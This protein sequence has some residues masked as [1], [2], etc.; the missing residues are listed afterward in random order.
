M[1]D[2]D[3]RNGGLAGHASLALIVALAGVASP[4][5]ARASAPVVRLDVPRQAVR[6]ALLDLAV[7]ARVSLGGDL[8]SCRG[9]TAGVSGVMTVDAAL[10]RLLAGSGCVH[11]IRAD[12]AVMI[13]RAPPP[14]ASTGAR[15]APPR[16][17]RPPSRPVAGPSSPIETTMVSD[18]IV[19]AQRQPQS[20]QETAAALTAVSG[21][22]IVAAGAADANDLSALVAGMTVT[23][24]G[25]GRNKILLRG[26]SDGAFTGLTQSTVG[27]YLNRVPLTY[28]A[29]DPDLKLVDIDRVEILRGPQGTLYGTGPIGGVLRIVP[30][31]PDPDDETL[32]L[33]GSISNTRSG[34]E[35]S[36]YGVIVNAPL[37]GERGAVR[38]VAYREAAD[39]YINDAN[40][41]LRRVNAGERR[42]QRLSALYRLS[43]EWTITA[44][45]VRQQI[46]T[47]DTHYIYRTSQGLTRANLVREP[48]AN[49]FAQTY[50]TLEGHGAWGRVEATLAKVSHDFSSRYDAS[51]A[52]RLFGSSGR[53]GA[54]D[55]GR[56]TD[57]WVG[58]VAFVSPR[59]QRFRWLA[60]GF[61]SD[62]RS[63]TDT[64]LQ[65]LWPQYG[66]VYSED[67]DD[68]RSEAAVFGEAAYDLTSRLSVI[69]GARYYRIDYEVDSL[70]EQGDAAR[71]F[72]GAGRTSGI[73]PKAVVDFT[74]NDRWSVYVLASQG[75]RVGGFNTGGP[76]GQS[77]SGAVGKPARRY[78]GDSLWN[79]ETG[80]KG[81]LFD[82]RLQARVALFH[83]EWDSLQSDQFLRSGLVYA[84][85]VGDGANTGLELE[86]NWRATAEL[87]MRANALF[88]DP[89]I[90][91]P[92]DAFNSRGDAGLPG[93]PAVSAN[94]NVAWR[95]GTPWGVDMVAEGRL[96]YV[97]PSRLTFDAARGYRMG[98][99]VT[100]RLSVGL[101]RSDWSASVF[102][103]NP[104]DTRANT[105]S[106]GDPFR[107][108]EALAT[109]PLRPRTVGLS[110]RWTPL[111]G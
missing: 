79:F 70:V 107:L 22:Q 44:G 71:E 13:R 105:F 110:L 62:S 68:R 55:E 111:G 80:A 47:Q 72:R 45:A 10:S 37:P 97:G 32:E 74:L 64:R 83:A 25:S 108:P 21:G 16:T 91:R 69:V 96:A 11:S 2:T 75:H 73:S 66:R 88:A 34:G 87:E 56:D 78:E 103:D 94:V 20:P 65:E 53:I 46:D 40:L 67:R 61:W 89:K 15:P 35:N 101:E 33:F 60:G 93:V 39:G 50:A 19:T 49:A 38:A 106:F 3:R 100:G 104:L 77:F 99:Y 82:G 90:V 1:A 52:L 59:E 26:M 42:G 102:V 9:L 30:R 76:I 98:D 48:H 63:N 5:A 41:N 17:P 29:P 4:L 85:N 12:G 27:V 43:P 95:R 7:Q 28:S 18:V 31:A 36:E 86:A 23:N 109:T 57:L 14:E 92:G 51:S 84:V 54:L 24:L 58:D 8:G 81:R 6:E